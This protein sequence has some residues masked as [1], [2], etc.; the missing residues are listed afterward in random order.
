[1]MQHLVDKLK[2]EGLIFV[3]RCDIHLQP[4]GLTGT[5]VISRKLYYPIKVLH[6]EK[7]GQVDPLDKMTPLSKWL[8]FPR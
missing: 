1:M 7:E 2:D 8:V 4:Q 6:H 5:F 3:E